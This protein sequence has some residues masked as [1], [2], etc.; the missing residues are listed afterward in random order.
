[1]SVV[2]GSRGLGTVSPVVGILS[3]V[4]PYLGLALGIV[5]I[6][7]GRKQYMRS[8]TALAAAGKVLGIIGV[9]W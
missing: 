8:P 7:L 3:I 9:V 1:M 6:V 5:A 2:A 4:V